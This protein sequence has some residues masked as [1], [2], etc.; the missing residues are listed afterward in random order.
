MAAGATDVSAVVREVA[1]VSCASEWPERAASIAE[2]RLTDEAPVV[3][4]QAALIA[5]G[6]TR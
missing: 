1:L 6:G 2:A 5:T 3:R 4:R